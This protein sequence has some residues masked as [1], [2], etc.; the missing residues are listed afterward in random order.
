VGDGLGPEVAVANQDDDWVVSVNLGDELLFN[1][2][3]PVAALHL[4]QTVLDNLRVSTVDI[5]SDWAIIA[6]VDHRIGLADRFADRADDAEAAF[7]QVDIILNQAR[8]TAG[9]EMTVRYIDSI[10]QY[11]ITQRIDVKDRLME[12]V[13]FSPTELSMSSVL[14]GHDCPW[15]TYDCGLPSRHC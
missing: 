14:C 2:A 10:Q 15:F 1:R 8:E 7:D 4:Y 13:T 3:D 5:A 9:S 11:S 12:D 6:V